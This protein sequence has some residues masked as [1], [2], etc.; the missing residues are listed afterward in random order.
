MEFG[1]YSAHSGNGRRCDRPGRGSGRKKPV[2]QHQHPPHGG[3]GGPE[4]V[5][6]GPAVRQLA[7]RSVDLGPLLEHRQDLGLLGRQQTVHRGPAR[8]A[9]D[10][11]TEPGAEHPPVRPDPTK[12]QDNRGR[13]YRPPLL[14]GPI[15]QLQQGGLGGRIDPSG[16]AA[17][18]PQPPFPSTSINFTAISLT[19]SDS[20]AISAFAASSSTS[21]VPA[22]MPGRDS[23][24]ADRAPSLATCRIRTTVVRSTPAAAA[25][26]AIVTS[27][28][29]TCR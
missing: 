25:A 8:S 16:D 20:R 5:Q 18:Y 1:R 3:W 13:R 27:P 7:M 10:E 9:V 19:G 28:R 14:D 21:R 22:L 6:V 29:I 24:S 4:P 23:A 12:V 11:V 2:V 15:E 17:T 26:S